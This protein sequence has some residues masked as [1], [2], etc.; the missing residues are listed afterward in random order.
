MKILEAD[1]ARYAKAR[2]E[3][4]GLV[5]MRINNSPG[6]FT[7]KDKRVMFKKSPISGFPDYAGYCK[8][9]RGWALEL[10]TTKGVLS[11]GQKEWIAKLSN[12]NV[13]VEVA[14]SFDDIDVF[15]QKVLNQ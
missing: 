1:L 10:K 11:D 7:N 4:S 3:K 14:R 5:F 9:G 2:L 12:S 13:I 8:S 6:L 15:I